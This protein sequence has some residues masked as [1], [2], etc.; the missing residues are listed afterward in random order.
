V[1]LDFVPYMLNQQGA[2]TKTSGS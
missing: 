1:Q 2:V